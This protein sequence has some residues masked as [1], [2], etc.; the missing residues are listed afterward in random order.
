MIF[1]P[2]DSYEHE[3]EEI[4]LEYWMNFRGEIVTIFSTSE[5][6]LFERGYIIKEVESATDY[7]EKKSVDHTEM[8][9]SKC[10]GLVAN[11][12]QSSGNVALCMS[13]V[14]ESCRQHR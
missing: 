1:V 7:P 9:Y 5:D 8:T 4:H 11:S 12:C 3:D 10:M 6:K 2:L 13:Q 14:S